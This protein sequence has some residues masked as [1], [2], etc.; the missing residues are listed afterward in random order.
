MISFRLR[1]CSSWSRNGLF[2]SSGCPQYDDTS[3]D[4]NPLLVA[5]HAMLNHFLEYDAV[6]PA[7]VVRDTAV[8][9]P[10]PC[11]SMGL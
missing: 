4:R 11:L 1:S 10:P 5:K 7:R 3:H 2:S 8:R 6:D 9:R